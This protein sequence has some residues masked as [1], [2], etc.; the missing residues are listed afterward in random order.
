MLIKMKVQITATAPTSYQTTSLRAFNMGCTPNSNGSYSASQG[1]DT[2]MEARVYL[3]RLAQNYY[4][5][6]AKAMKEAQR[7]I[8]LHDCLTLDAVTARI[9]PIQD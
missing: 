3:D 2:K 8:R 1:F 5:E 6:D 9:E 7:D 4:E